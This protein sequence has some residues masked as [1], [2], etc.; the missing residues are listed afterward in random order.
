MH[1]KLSKVNLENVVEIVDRE[2]VIVNY[3]SAI[4]TKNADASGSTIS[5]PRVFLAI[6]WFTKK[7]SCLT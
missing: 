2:M 7:R 6:R 1:N 5:T 3:V 4:S